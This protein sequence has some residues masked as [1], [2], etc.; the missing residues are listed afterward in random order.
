[1]FKRFRKKVE[2]TSK[3]VNAVVVKADRL[4]DNGR[5]KIALVTGIVVVGVIFGIASDIVSIKVGVETLKH[6]KEKN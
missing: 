2:K 1:M 4:I 6:L 3:D 5:A